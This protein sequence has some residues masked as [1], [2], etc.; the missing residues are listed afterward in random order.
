MRAI[1]NQERA[2]VA[3]GVEQVF[4]TAK[5]KDDGSGTAK[6]TVSGANSAGSVGGGGGT[7]TRPKV[8]CVEMIEQTC[9]TAQVTD[10]SFG[11]SGV[12][13]TKTPGGCVVKTTSTCYP[14]NS[15]K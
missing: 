2:A 3:G 14:V 1:T 10:W 8:A 15:S 4:V 12:S 13:M 11:I 6:S 7:A 9:Q 5:K